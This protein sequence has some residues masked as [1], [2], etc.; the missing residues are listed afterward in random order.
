MYTGVRSHGDAQRVTSYETACQALERASKT[1]TGRAR[2]EKQDG[3][4][5]GLNRNHGVTWVRAMGTARESIA[6]RLYD[7]DVVIWNADNSVTIDNHGS[8]TTSEFA[9]RFLP[10][11]IHLSYP[12]TVRG[13][14]G[15]HRGIYYNTDVPEGS[16]WGAQKLCFGGLVTFH[17]QGADWLPDEDSVEPFNFLDLDRKG[18][19]AVARDYPFK[20]F[21]SWLSMAP[22]HL[23]IAHVEWDIEEC[24]VALRDRDFR[25][26]AEY[27]PTI[28][29]PSGFGMDHRIKPL[30]ITVNN[31]DAVIT[32]GS[33]RKLR[34]ALY[35]QEGL[36]SEVAFTT[37]KADEYDR[38]MA[39]VR[40][41]VALD[42]IHEGEYGAP[43]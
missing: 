31:R 3:Y 18:A 13:H 32:T 20:D 42:M 4:H 19:R 17:Q 1:P 10:R 7:T 41:L 16:Y 33:L 37:I 28:T 27:L 2:V 30:P 29:I 25:R 34:L 43:W 12:T 35:K 36:F 5:L 21:E 11:G 22:H 26:A 8:V 38:R 15:G 40:E 14:T 6:F 23:D 39:R 9:R 24:L